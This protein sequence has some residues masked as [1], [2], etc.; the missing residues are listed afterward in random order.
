MQNSSHE[1][2]F[3]MSENV[4]VKQFFLF[5]VTLLEDTFRNRGKKQPQNDLLSDML[6]VHILHKVK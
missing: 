2:E 3:N 5:R 4:K 1:N 6:T